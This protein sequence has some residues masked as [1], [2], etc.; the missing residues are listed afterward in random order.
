MKK[1]IIQSLAAVA[2][3]LGASVSPAF[4]A[5]PDKPVTI[6]VGFAAGGAVDA[7]ARIVA[8]QLSLAWK[9]PVI[10]DVHAGAGGTTAA[11]LA[12]KATPDGYTLL[13]GVRSMTMSSALYTRLPYDPAKSFIPVAMCAIQP[14][15]LVIS[16][17]VGPRTLPAL[18]ADMKA[19]PGKYTF[20][21][22]GNGSVPHMA[23]ELFQK[24]TGTKLTHVPYRG[25][26]AL[27][28]DMLG[29]RV[30][31]SFASL[32]NF[33]ASIRDGSLTP[34]AIASTKRSPQLPSLPTFAEAGVPD[35]NVDTWFGLL[36]PAGTPN[37]VVQKINATVV[38]ALK[39]PEVRKKLESVGAEVE[40]KTPAEFAAMY[41]D[42][43]AKYG[44]LARDLGLRID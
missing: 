10:V 36:A 17:Q 7:T 1:R 15:V 20:G 22:T 21:T 40:L 31:M 6:M 19:S 28:V 42:D 32:P 3:G 26:S 11:G 12:S 29:Q 14:T 16:K 2:V 23:G 9:Q 43:L 25:T 44:K 30:D 24:Q 34:L 33:I 37:D 18:L 4:A 38:D 13:M 41:N 27:Q 35:F 8:E 5:F 39:K